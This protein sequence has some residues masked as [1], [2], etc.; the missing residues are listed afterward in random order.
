ML[1]SYGRNGSRGFRL[2]HTFAA[3]EKYILKCC[4]S[5]DGKLLA[6]TS[7]DCRVCLWV[8]PPLVP[9]APS[10]PPPMLQTA[11]WDLQRVLSGHQRWVWDCAFSGCS[12]YLVTASSDHTGRLWDLRSGKLSAAYNGHQ[13]PVTC[14]VLDDAQI[15]PPLP[16]DDPAP[17]LPAATVAAAS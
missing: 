13:K 16:V 14:I 10:A 12:S 4:V 15:P 7:A 6:T 8:V 17:M 1:S 3:H 2:V 5:P 11:K 9:L